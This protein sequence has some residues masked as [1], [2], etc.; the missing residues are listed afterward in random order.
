MPRR[1]VPDRLADQR[2]NE[3]LGDALDRK[4]RLYVTDLE[5][6][7]PRADNADREQLRRRVSQRR[8]V[9]C[10]GTVVVRP[11]AL[12]RLGD[13]IPNLFGLWQLAG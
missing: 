2:E 1:L 7:A 4:R 3:W 8:D 10:D 5:E 6:P 13:D 9:V 12:V 11:V